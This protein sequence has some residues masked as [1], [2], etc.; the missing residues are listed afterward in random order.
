MKLFKIFSF[1][2]FFFVF[3]QANSWY[4]YP[5][6]C[7]STSYCFSTELKE[8]SKTDNGYFMTDTNILS[9]SNLNN[10]LNTKLSNYKAYYWTSEFEIKDYYSWTW[11]IFDNDLTLTD[12]LNI[13]TN[14]YIAK[15]QG[16]NIVI[17]KTYSSWKDYLFTNF[18]DVIDELHQ[19]FPFWQKKNK[20]SDLLIN[21]VWYNHWWKYFEIKNVCDDYTC[22]KTRYLWV[23]STSTNS[24]NFLSW[25]VKHNSQF[26]LDTFKVSSDY[27]ISHIYLKAWWSANFN[28]WFEDYLD[29][30]AVNTKYKYSISYKYEW[31]PIK[32]LFSEVIKVAND[33]KV[34]SDTIT[35]DVLD[36]IID[37]TVLNNTFKK[38]RIWVKEWLSLTKVGKITFYL[39]VENLN[40]GDKFDTTAVNQYTPLHVI[41]NDNVKSWESLIYWFSKSSNDVGYNIWDTFSVSVNLFDEFNNRHYDY[42]DWYDIS[43]DSWTS[44][45]LEISKFW[46]DIYSDNIIWIKSTETSPY[47]INFKFRIIKAWYHELTW[48]KIKIRNKQSTSSYLS[49]ASYSYFTIIPSNLYDGDQKMKIYIKS[50]LITDFPITCTSW[51]VTLNAICTSDNFSWCNS[52]MNQSITFS[53]E[54]DNGSMWTL[55]IRDYAHNVKNFNYTMNHIDKTAPVISV[56]K[57]S[58][59]LSSN[60]YSFK[61]NDDSI[62]INFFEK[63]TSN[64]ISEI[65][66]LI[67]I[68]WITIYDSSVWSSNFDSNI[69]DFFKLSGNKELYIKATD[70]YW[71]FSDK[72]INFV[73]HPDIFDPI[74][75][76]ISVNQNNTKYANN[77]DFYIYTISLKDKYDN[78]IINKSISFINQ[79]CTAYTWCKT[80]RTNMSSLTPSWEDALI[81]YWYWW[82]SNYLWH[83][84]FMVKSFS[85]W[86]FTNRFK[87]SINDWDDNYINFWSPKDYYISNIDNNS[88]KKL[89]TWN[90]VA[91]DNDG[92]TWDAKP[93]YGTELKYKLNV[94]PLIWYSSIP[95][96][97][98]DFKD[99]IRAYEETTSQVEWVS[100]II[101]LNTKNPIFSARINSSIIASSFWTP[102]LQISDNINLSTLVINYTLWWKNISH[103]L[104]KEELWWDRTPIM[105]KN[106]TNDIFLWVEVIWLLQWS[107]KSDFTWQEKNF[108]DISKSEIRSNIRKKAF[109]QIS[110]MSNN[111]IVNWVKYVIWDINLSWEISWY[112]T[113]VVKDWNVIINWDLNTLW[114]KF[115]IIVL[116]DNYNVDNWFLSKW[117]IYVTPNVSRI[118]AIIYA[119]GWFI[120]SDILWNPYTF[121]SISRSLD[122]K[123]QLYMKWT[124]FTRNTIGW[125]ILSWWNYILP[126]WTKLLPTETNYNKAFIYD[127]NYIRRWK[128]NCIESS[129]WVC[130][131]NKGAFVI[132]YD[133]KV[134]TNPP[135]LFSN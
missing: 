21:I 78:P 91:S 36:N 111:Q 86:E 80:V 105:I 95:I 60:N 14:F 87:I 12:L 62:K 59:L 39:S 107:W 106:D 92:L 34:T 6:V 68:N 123:N 54:S 72:T 70:K 88:F 44:D 93:V 30:W 69:S 115:W 134:Q 41:P 15:K 49:P 119:D 3:S 23:S 73:V 120:S 53:S 108:S 102:W 32:L 7:S 113:L 135:K 116:K 22:H 100:N 16:S 77:A 128:N 117:N 25:I 19:W 112:E 33:Y 131:Y 47:I 18:S 133:S 35:Q 94:I 61:A 79:D 24:Y 1:L 64:C 83:I 67:K 99:D 45:F 97:L 27:S 9:V 114:N 48:F 84:N 58:T 104:S 11:N 103:F 126:W 43:L 20:L 110:N 96:N 29:V 57:W 76:T 109:T 51:S 132:E 31:E 42:I 101:W 2:L 50:P 4:N 89:F 28:F 63:T 82:L 66:Y 74:K 71:N 37:L 56:F 122:L 52:S 121:D 46:S 8:I 90:I 124:L 129:P 38:V 125:A 118:N 17:D 13:N 65:K 40:T 98:I 75:T 81:E 127:L 130:K 5:Y 55:S 85:P 26:I 10:Y